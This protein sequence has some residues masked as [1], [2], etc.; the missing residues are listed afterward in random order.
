ML[1]PLYL[2]TINVC[3]FFL[4]SGIF[5]QKIVEEETKEMCS[6]KNSSLATAHT[7]YVD[8]PGTLGSS[9]IKNQQ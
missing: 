6:Q 8:L 5:M 1:S 7:E 4:T 3:L 9:T 2:P